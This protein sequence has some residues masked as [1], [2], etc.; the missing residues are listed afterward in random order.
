M[1]LN[2]V[3]KSKYG[4]PIFMLAVALSFSAS[5]QNRE[6]GMGLGGLTYTGDLVRNYDL[7]RNRPA[8]LFYLRNN[9]SEAV[10]FRYGLTAGIISGDDDNPIDVL[11]LNRAA[12]FDIFILSL[13]DGFMI[14]VQSVGGESPAGAH[15]HRRRG[16]SASF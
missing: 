10:S 9:I 3:G 14:H 16:C 1:I 11:G 13:A 4:F 6:I 5:A 7:I 12:S 2:S 8:V 15:G